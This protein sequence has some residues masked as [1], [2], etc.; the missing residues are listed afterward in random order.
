[1][2]YAN[3]G[4]RRTGAAVLALVVAVFGA[5]ML[6][7]TP[8]TGVAPLLECEGPISPDDEF[9]GTALDRCRW[10][11]ILNED[12]AGY[13][14]TDGH[15]GIKALPGDILG[16]TFSAQNVILQSAPTDGSWTAK[17]RLS[18]DGTDD[19]LQ[20]G[21]VIHSANDNHGKLVVLRLPDG[22]W[23]VE[24]NRT[25]NGQA[26]YHQ[27][28][29]LPANLH[30]GIWLRM[31]MSAGVL[32]GEYSPDGTE[33][34]PVDAEYSTTNFSAPMIGLAAYNGD[35]SEEAIFGS[36]E[37]GEPTGPIVKV[38]STMTIEPD[39]TTYSVGESGT[40]TVSV[41]APGGIPTGE[42]SLSLN[43]AAPVARPLV[44]G[45][46]I[47]RIGYFTAPGAVD[48]KAVYTG[49]AATNGA[50]STATIGVRQQPAGG[51]VEST[52]VL[53]ADKAAYA[54]GEKAIALV[55]VAGADGS[56]PTGTL[57]LSANG[58]PAASVTLINGSAAFAVGPFDSAGTVELTATYGGDHN[59]AGSQ[60]TL[61]VSVGTT[62]GSAP[63]TST[64]PTTL[65]PQATLPPSVVP[66]PVLKLLKRRVK[67]KGDK[68]TVQLRCDGT[69][70]CLANALAKKGKAK[71]AAGKITLLGAKSGTA[72]L[73]LT[74]R[75]KRLLEKTR[76]V[77]AVV[78]VKMA[79][80]QTLKWKVTL[81]RAA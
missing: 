59:T 22:T 71:L 67:V 58:G 35:G 19:Y 28:A 15:L 8:A 36:F 43:G 1:M 4:W 7:P 52:M 69:G 73:K 21:L 42:V 78:N 2:R 14:V 37:V 10:T 76:Q 60:T 29:V 31:T 39:K 70:T 33:W 9:N 49:D 54:V 77:R 81:K 48:I 38:N 74:K 17:T 30:T 80:G 41:A 3:I 66:E 72:K 61:I 44:D 75:C 47:F 20:A 45:V 32:T 56:V 23:V 27:S 13:E 34:T 53:T 12:P 18:V 65:P 68:A 46:A 50:E 40:V 11:S 51:K 55:K 64:P 57:T 16:E 79:S 25:A 63:A 5:A 24:L 6:A 26:D 62:S